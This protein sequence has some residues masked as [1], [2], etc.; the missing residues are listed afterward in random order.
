MADMNFYKT[1][2]RAKGQI[3]VP[4]PVREVLGAEEGDDLAFFVTE[5]GQVIVERLQTIPPEQAWF[6]TERWQ[7]MEHE[8]QE[9]IDAGRVVRFGSVDDA[10]K[11]LE[12]G[13]NAG[14]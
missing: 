12:R 6:W 11:A 14:D 2:V 4:G 8:A 10:V 3:T 1:R 7:K 5:D 9:D 13:K